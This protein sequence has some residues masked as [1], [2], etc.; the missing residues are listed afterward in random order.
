MISWMIPIV[1]YHLAMISWTIPIVQ[2]ITNGCWHQNRLA[3]FQLLLL[4]VFAAAAMRVVYSTGMA[5]GDDNVDCLLQKAATLYWYKSFRRPKDKNNSLN[6]IVMG[7]E[8]CIGLTTQMITVRRRALYGSWTK[9]T[10]KFWE[11]SLKKPESQRTESSKKTWRT[12]IV[13]CYAKL[14]CRA[15]IIGSIWSE[16]RT[17]NHKTD[18]SIYLH[19]NI[20][21]NVP[22]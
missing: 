12:C 3:L 21:A 19:G 13:Q 8:L 14:V 11:I 10:S 2:Y 17:E 16:N 1:Q 6:V 20:W 18:Q 7:C 15:V 5:I 4:M 9:F 22:L